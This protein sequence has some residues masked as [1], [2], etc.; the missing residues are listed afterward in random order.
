MAIAYPRAKFAQHLQ[1]TSPSDLEQQL[2]VGPGD[3]LEQ[4][5]RI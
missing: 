5:P 1:G 3:L 4:A 2:G